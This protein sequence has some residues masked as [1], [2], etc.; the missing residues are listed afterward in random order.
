MEFYQF[1][2]RQYGT[3]EP[4]LFSE[5]QY[6]TYSEPWLYKALNRLCEEGLLSRFEKGVYYI[7]TKTLL[8]TSVLDPR[9]VI[10]KKYVGTKND[11]LGYYSGVTFLNQIGISTQMPNVIEIYTNK[12]TGTVREVKIG[13]QRVLLRR[14]RTP[15]TAKNADVQSFLEMMNSVPAAY[16]DEERRRIVTDFIASRGITR[17][18]ISKYAPAFPDRAMRTMIESEV[19]YSVTR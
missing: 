7:P 8:G 17:A 11:R 18:D 6:K 4:I 3:N 5:I 9:K 15:I 14:A 19:I 2:L 16:F 12:E 10:E 13:S 1:L